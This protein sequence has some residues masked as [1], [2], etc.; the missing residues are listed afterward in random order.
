VSDGFSARQ[1]TASDVIGLGGDGELVV[2]AL[3]SRERVDT[4]PQGHVQV[5]GTHQ[6]TVQAVTIEAGTVIGH[7]YTYRRGGQCV[8]RVDAG[9]DGTVPRECAQLPSDPAVP[10]AQS[11]GAL[12][13]SA[14]AVEVVRDVV[15][16]RRTGPWQGAGQLG[17]DLP[18]MVRAG[19]PYWVG[20]SGVERSGDVR[21]SVVDVGSGLRVDTPIVGYRDG[22][23]MARAQPL[24]PG[25]YW[26]RIDGGGLS[27][28]TQILMS[29]PESE[30]W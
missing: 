3:S 20:I 13:S 25:L 11:H 22:A 9:G 5:V 27:P 4:A 23:V 14:E 16:D 21:C 29:T 10:L 15:T 7:R 8:A 17:L 30:R 28:V 12:A 24:P 1:L 6:P 18:D 2:A 26:V 19:Q